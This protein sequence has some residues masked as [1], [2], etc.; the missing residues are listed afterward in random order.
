[1]TALWRVD[2]EIT[3]EF[4]KQFYYLAL[5]EHKPKAEALRLAKLR[6][7]HSNSKVADPRVWAAFVLNGD[8]ATA[9]PSVV[10]WWEITLLL[11]LISAGVFAGLWISL[12]Q[13]RRIDRQDD[14]RAV[15]R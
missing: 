2:D 3:A 10:S 14:A 15:I 13:H 9:L 5:N 7:L 12:R 6:F 4:M 11:V 1:M 8:G